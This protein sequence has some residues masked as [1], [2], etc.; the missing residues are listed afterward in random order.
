MQA[1]KVKAGLRHF[2][3]LGGRE[4]EMQFGMMKKEE[5]VKRFKGTQIT[6]ELS[7]FIDNFS[8]YWVTK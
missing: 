7:D 4:H 3:G 1:K 6:K 2:Q 5:A 8:L